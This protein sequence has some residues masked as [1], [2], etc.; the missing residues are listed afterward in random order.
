MKTILLVFG[1]RP[2]AYRKMSMAVNP[3]GDGLACGRIEESGLEQAVKERPKAIQDA[4]M[5]FESE[6][7]VYANRKFL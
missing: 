3:C 6:T 2:E 5:V 7:Q 4:D 1:T